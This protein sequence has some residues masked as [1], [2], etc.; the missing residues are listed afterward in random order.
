MRFPYFAGMKK[1]PFILPYDVLWGEMD[2]LGHVNNAVYFRYFE[3]ARINILHDLGFDLDQR[4]WSDKG[5]ILAKIECSF[6]R[7]IIYPDKLIIGSWVKKIGNSSILIDHEIWSESQKSVV[8]MAE[9]VMVF[10]NFK[11][12]ETIRV[13][14]EFRE[15]VRE[16][17][18]DSDFQLHTP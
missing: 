8:T 16:L 18:N 14:D 3:Q 7:P 2:S 15:K 12:G 10:A 6:R 1:Y 17:Q 5:P 11:T 4:S 9:T 13:S